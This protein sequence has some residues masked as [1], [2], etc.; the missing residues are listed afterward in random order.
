MSVFQPS[1]EL[2]ELYAEFALVQR[3]IAKLYAK[4][5][6]IRQQIEIEADKVQ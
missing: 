6:N 4:L 5:D 3:R 1:R 2:L